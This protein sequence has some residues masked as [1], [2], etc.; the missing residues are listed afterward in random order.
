MPYRN[1]A[2]LAADT[3]A[4]NRAREIVRN[5]LPPLCIGLIFM[6]CAVLAITT[7]RANSNIALLWPGNAI[8]AALLIRMRSFNWLAM[9]S[10]LAIGGIAANR[11]AGGDAWQMSIALTAVNLLEIAAAVYVFRIVKPLPYPRLTI[12]QAAFMTLVMGVII[13]GVAAMLAGM[14]MHSMAGE[15]LVAT[16]RHWWGSSALGA[17]LLAPPIILFSK[18]DLARLLQPRYVWTNALML[19]LCV[20]ATYLAVRYLHF[21]FVVIAI[22]PMV[23][24]YQMGGFG[25]AVLSA[26][27]VITVIVLWLLDIKP[28]GVNVTGAEASLLNLPFAALIATAMP[29]VAV[30]LGTD[31]R[32]QVARLLR[33]SE[34]RFRESMESSPLGVIM[35][36]RNGQWSFANAALQDMLGYTQQELSEMNIES[37]AHPD[38]LPD[39][40]HRWGKLVTQQIDSY[41]ITRR[42]QHRNGEWVWVNCA[43]SLARDEDGLPMHFVAQVES[44]QERRHAEA[45]L[46]AERE[47][48]RI[49]LASIGDAVITA[50]PQGRITYVN[51]AA[52]QLLGRSSAL[53]VNQNM[54]DVLALT[55]AEN[56]TKVESLIDL[57]REQLTPMSRAEP[58]A[59]T[60][61]DGSVRHV[62][63][64]VTP[65]LDG[66]EKLTGFVTVVHDV[67]ESMQRT[68]DLQHRANHDSLTNLLNRLA[69][70]R[71]L[72]RAFAESRAQGTPATLI[73][74]DLDKFKLVNDSGGH[75]AGDAVLRHVAAVLQRSVRPTDSVARLGGD[76]FMVLLRNCD[77]ARSRDVSQRLL[78]ALNPLQTTWGGRTYTTGASL[79]QAQC[80]EEFADPEEWSRAA[81]AAC[82]ESKHSGRGT[83]R[84]WRSV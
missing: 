24:A 62:S 60:R 20:F 78:Q 54:R 56:S 1:K 65:V 55:D 23:A 30:G 58:C 47:M 63:D 76:E 42:F 81:D 6:A 13:T 15:P 35:L 32:R 70:E 80:G 31:A 44:L 29:P 51:D 16:V 33:A 4:R 82:Y 73:A 53:M 40:W 10:A 37:L 79:G 17:C 48:L 71:D 3:A 64:V 57:S 59:L 14:V 12:Y 26:C 8:A 45:T 66:N 38:D 50:D 41:R 49:T 2:R 75:A 72:H 69:F 67:T 21:P 18:S 84:N 28:V 77:L 7:S 27:N 46:A 34:Q 74:M 52:V 9:G 83:L 39:I 61:P 68:H 25:T 43:V 22:F 5:L 11:L 19:P 36:D